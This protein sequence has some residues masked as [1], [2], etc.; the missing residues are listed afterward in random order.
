ML[1]SHGQSGGKHES[2]QFW[3]CGNPCILERE[4]IPTEVIRDRAEC[5]PVYQILRKLW[6]RLNN[7]RSWTSLN[8][9]PHFVLTSFWG[10]LTPDATFARLSVSIDCQD[11]RSSGTIFDR[12][13][14]PANRYT[15]ERELP[16][17][18]WTD[19][20]SS[21]VSISKPTCGSHS[22]RRQ[23]STK[24]KSTH[25]SMR[26]QHETT[27]ATSHSIIHAHLNTTPT[28]W[29]SKSTHVMTC[30][31]SFCWAPHLR[32]ELAPCGSKFLEKPSPRLDICHMSRKK[33][34][35]RKLNKSLR[36]LLS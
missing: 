11:S 19:C 2:P 10:A 5:K 34:C 33:G 22:D 24:S 27:Q 1:C 9:R 21:F 7:F 3:V 6:F 17:Y 29:V 31:K 8:P 26:Q 35:I 15:H 18:C 12:S 28:F 20:C 14:T 23:R 16:T 32:D 30:R 13:S 25:M 36:S 4:K